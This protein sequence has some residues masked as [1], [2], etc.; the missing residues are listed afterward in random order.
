MVLNQ[1]QCSIIDAL[2]TQLQGVPNGSIGVLSSNSLPAVDTVVQL[3]INGY[4]LSTSYD[5]LI[6][7]I[8]ASSTGPDYTIIWFEDGHGSPQARLVS[9]SPIGNPVGITDLVVD[10]PGSV[11]DYMYNENASSGNNQW[12]AVGDGDGAAAIV[13]SAVS[14]PSLTSGYPIWEGVNNYNGV[15]SQTTINAHASSDLFSIPVPLV[16]HNVDLAGDAFPAFGTYGMG[17][18]VKVNVTDPR[19]PR[20]SSFSVRVIGWTIQP[21]D[22]GQGNEQI[23]LV[24]DEATGAGTGA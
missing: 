19:F 10:Y 7:S 11:I 14:T 22:E 9:Q 4:D 20:G 15:T 18:Y 23:T 13:G 21:P 1:G 2:W 12:W 16:T 24:F 3:T 17:D 8:L 5:A 6:Q